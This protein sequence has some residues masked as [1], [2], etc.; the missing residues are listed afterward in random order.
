MIPQ[1]PFEVALT[2][3]EVLT[4][5]PSVVAE[6]YSKRGR[7]RRLD[8]D[9]DSREA[10]S[11]REQ[12]WAIRA[13][14]PAGSWFATGTGQPPQRGPWPTPGPLPLTLPVA[15]GLPPWRAPVN[16]DAP[17]VGERE[18]FALFEAIAAALD[19]ELPGARLV[20]A[21][22]DDGA[23]EAE[24]VSSTGVRA[25]GL[26]QRIAA[27]RVEATLPGRGAAAAQVRLYMAER[28]AR[29]F[30]PTSVARRLADRLVALSAGTP[31]T[32][33]CR[34][35]V[36]APA[37]AADIL[38]TL[39]PYLTTGGA[40]PARWL[41]GGR[42]A[43]DR[44]TIIDDGRLPGGL[45]EAGAD[46]EGMPTRAVTLV[47]QGRWRQPLCAFGDRRQPDWTASGCCSRPSW[48][49]FPATAPSHL[50]IKPDPGLSPGALLAD[51]RGAYL[52]AATGPILVDPDRDRLDIPV[53]GFELAR[54]GAHP[55]ARTHLVGSV[56]ELLQG[57]VAVARDLQ[58]FPGRG[59]IG[60]PTLLVRG[61]DLV[62][63]P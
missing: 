53:C 1:R 50:F 35:L 48:R 41:A 51:A 4:A 30:V 36:L 2:T 11:L 46:G 55:L 61:P 49:D 37:L 62:A 10:T 5:D 12:G 57:I 25:S 60:A 40:P 45:G 39:V 44:L 63:R 42:F 20:R 21:V 32:R 9:G 54:E 8:L 31:P 27:L 29:K 6:V 17:L 23:S 52:L 15:T 28:E 43:S 38:A 3:L 18:G 13:G 47:E 56:S 58:F 34:D 7:S 59:F 26:R 14:S 22:L 19:T 33:P 24:L 16:L